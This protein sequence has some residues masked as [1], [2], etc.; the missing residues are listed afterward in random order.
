MDELIISKPSTIFR[1]LKTD[2]ILFRSFLLVHL[3][4]KKKQFCIKN[5]H[6]IDLSRHYL[7]IYYYIGGWNKLT[8]SILWDNCCHPASILVISHSQ[9]RS[10]LYII[11]T[12]LKN[13][14]SVLRWRPKWFIQREGERET[15]QP[16]LKKEYVRHISPWHN[17]VPKR[18]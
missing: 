6:C 18:L 3:G 4:L 17:F 8:C 9:F 13:M 5:Q 11:F 14:H 7:F 1:N 2:S 15:V 10:L 12:N 16:T